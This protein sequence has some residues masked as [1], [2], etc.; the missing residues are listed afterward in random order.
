MMEL[1]R[2]DTADPERVQEELEARGLTDG[3]PVVP[4]TSDRVARMLEK[5]GFNAGD[6]VAVLPP[7]LGKATPMRKPWPMFDRRSYSI[8]RPLGRRSSRRMTF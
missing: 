7:L 1:W 8:S 5:S 2:G 4:P 6:T 3:L